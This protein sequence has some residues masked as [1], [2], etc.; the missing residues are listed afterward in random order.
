MRHVLLP[1]SLFLALSFVLASLAGAYSLR[2]TCF[3]GGGRYTAV[4][5]SP[6]QP[7]RV[8]IG[9]DVAGIYVSEDAGLTYTP[10]GNGLHGLA[11][12]GILVPPGRPDAVM[13]LCDRGLFY[14]VDR[15]R[16]MH[17]ISAKIRY[18]ERFF[19]SNLLLFAPDGHL[20]A[21][22]DLDGVFK[23]T[24]P[25]QPDSLEWQVEPLLGLGGSKVNS[26]AY[27]DAALYA[28]MDKGIRVWREDHWKP[29]NK[30]FPMGK[31]NFM[32]LIAPQGG[33]L[34]TVERFA[35]VFAYSQDKDRWES[36]G[37][38]K[39]QLPG[40]GPVFFKALA[41]NPHPTPNIFVATH[42][43]Y[44]PRLLLSTTDH[45]ATWRVLTRFAHTSPIESWAMGMESV[46]TLLFLDD[47]KVGY[48]MD[49]WNTW[50]SLDGGNTWAQSV[51]GLQNSVVN[52]IAFPND[53]TETVFLAVADNGLM[54]TENNGLS[55]ERRMKDVVDGHGQSLAFTSGSPRK[56]YLVMKAWF[57]KDPEGTHLFHLYKSTDMGRS[58]A[59]YP[60][61]VQRKTFTQGYVDEQPSNVVVDPDN[62][63]VVYVAT[64]GYG[65]LRL[66]TSLP[67]PRGGFARADNILAGVATPF[68]KGPGT[69]RIHPENPGIIYAGTL[70][71][72]VYKTEDHGKNWKQLPGTEG[73]IFGMAMDTTNPER[74]LAAAGGN[75]ILLTESSGATWRSIML[76]FDPGPDTAT[77][78]VAF[79]ADGKTI[80]VGT[81]AFNLSAAQGLYVSTD[82]GESFQLV[83]T[84][85]A[86]VGVLIIEPAPDN[87]AAALV[88]YNG[89]GTFMAEP[90]QP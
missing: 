58:W 19:G 52:D 24:P 88:G 40:E 13:V 31:D 60:I 41:C 25:A 5:V 17:L 64:N 82:Q 46:E 59:Y 75:K 15:G 14:S 66:D 67:P 48:L 89:V 55:W 37:P 27:R 9:S 4:A 62:D 76:P 63:D 85:I 7:Q 90:T 38:N 8:Y 20:Y 54:V 56:L 70:G 28:A 68:V 79:G 74:L 71:G 80:F 35:G 86:P 72:G 47:G 84:D 49:W 29:F 1:T 51:T 45:G 33:P 44:W 11:V 10:V 65:V 42:P 73:F 18:D 6:D 50:R 36:L 16:S 3:G 22:S 53:N 12:A 34:L 32:D 77:Y 78:A 87:P 61:A 83:E 23:L 81:H 43:E 30:G 2:P 39:A 21:G 57:P 26:L 69:L